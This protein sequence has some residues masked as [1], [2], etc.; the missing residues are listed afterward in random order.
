MEVAIALLSVPVSTSNDIFSE[1][2]AAENIFD[3]LGWLNEEA[4]NIINQNRI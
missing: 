4:G 1:K 2:D 3:L